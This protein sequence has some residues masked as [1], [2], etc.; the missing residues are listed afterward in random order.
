M[1][2]SEAFARIQHQVLR[3]VSAVPEAKLTTYQS[4]GEHLAVMPRHVAYI[5][6]QLDDA[7]KLDIPWYRVVSA[8]G[9]LG[10]PKRDPNGDTQ[11]DLLE[12]EGLVVVGNA[13]HPALEAFFLPCGDLTH[14]IP[15]QP[16]PAA[17]ADSQPRSGANR[18]Q[19]RLGA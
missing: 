5:L 11:A 7:T 14:G 9:S 16:R 6:S 4:I 17:V 2:K 19:R 10:V 15:G 3:I 18:P 1:A 12:R 13:V 8:N